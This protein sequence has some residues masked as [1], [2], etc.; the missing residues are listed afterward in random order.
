MSRRTAMD[1]LVSAAALTRAHEDGDG[2]SYD[3]VTGSTPPLDLIGGLVSLIKLTADLMRSDPTR[4]LTDVLDG[5]VD[6]NTEERG[7]DRIPDSI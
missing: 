4:Q 5:I 6:V 1:N 2:A 3:L 7:G